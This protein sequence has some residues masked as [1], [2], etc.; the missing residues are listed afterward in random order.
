[1]IKNLFMKKLRKLLKIS[2]LMFVVAFYS[3]SKTDSSFNI[4]PDNATMMIVFDGKSLSEKSGFKSFSDS[5]TYEFIKKEMD[6]D[7]MEN[8]KLMEPIMKNSSESGLDM[9]K[10]FFLFAYKKET[11]NFFGL[12]FNLVDKAKL[13]ST[14]ANIS[15]ASEEKMEINTDGQWSYMINEEENSPLFIWDA[16][17]L[18][19]LMGTSGNISKDDYL[20]ESKALWSQKE[21]KSLSSNKDFKNFIKNRKDISMWVDYSIF[22][23]NLPPMQKIL[24]QSNMPFDMSGTMLY[25]YTDFQKGKLVASYDVVMNDEMKNF[26]KENQV[27]KDKFDQ[28]ILDIFPA[29]SFANFSMAFDFLAYFEVLKN[30]LE[31]NQQDMENVDAQFKAQMGMTIKEAL[32]EFSGEVVLNVHRIGFEEVEKIDYMAYY[33]S[34]G[35][36]DIDAFKKMEMQPVVYYSIGAE[37]NNDKLFGILIQ[38]MGGMIEKTEDYYT[39]NNQVFNGYLGLFGKKLLFTNDQNL[40][41]DAADGKVEG[42]SLAS[43]DVAKNLKDFPAYA[44]I[45]LDLDDYPAEIKDGLSDIMGEQNSIS[46]SAFMSMFKKLEIKPKSANE[47]EMTLYM[48]D[49]SKNSLE[50]MLRGIDNNI[51]AIAD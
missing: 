9:S 7:E 29:K 49:D 1:M 38:A 39:I 19:V 4:V 3:C 34:G 10:D 44:F 45:D 42:E 40:I 43:S 25:F 23:D 5:K 30:T 16:N 46:F 18:L 28:D 48:K 20:A 21:D 2:L 51:E 26:L 32:N 31:Q 41:E 13:E 24:M 6:S 36:E 8:F 50:L 14:I 37:M 47:A 11:N 22:Y 17:K 35:E 33:Q 15:K 27:I 12:V